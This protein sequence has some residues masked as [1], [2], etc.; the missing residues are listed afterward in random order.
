MRKEQR[1]SEVSAQ[2]TWAQLYTT[3]IRNDL[4]ILTPA[5]KKIAVTP[6]LSNGVALL[7]RQLEGA[8]RMIGELKKRSR[9]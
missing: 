3:S 9:I 5:M 1:T 4:K 6:E 2:L 7:L 8:H